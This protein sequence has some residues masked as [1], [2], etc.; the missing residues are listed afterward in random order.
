MLITSLRA[1]YTDLNFYITLGYSVYFMLG[2]F[3][4]KH[5]KKT[6]WKYIKLCSIVYL[7]SC[8]VTLVFIT[9]ADNVEKAG[10]YL[11]A[12]NVFV[13]LMSVS[14]FLFAKNLAEQEKLHGI[15]CRIGKLSKYTM[16][17]YLVHPL[18]IEILNDFAGE[19]FSQ[20][21]VLSVLVISILIYLL[22]LVFSVILSGIP[23]IGK[24]ISLSDN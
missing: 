9:N 10:N 7:V 3:L 6:G 19:L 13:L 15:L 8:M 23:C 12:D 11:L 5:I 24:T 1:V 14:V 4:E 17:I 22:A 2:R 20:V 16:G 18:F 21:T